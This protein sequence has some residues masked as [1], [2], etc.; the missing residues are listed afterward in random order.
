MS[1]LI[2]LE[3]LCKIIS[4]SRKKKAFLTFHSVGDRDGVASAVA[5]SSCFEKSKV[6]TPD[7]ITGN[8]RKMLLL[9]HYSKKIRNTLP[10]D[11]E[12]VIITDTNNLESLG[13]LGQKLLRFRGPIIFIDHH[14]LKQD[15][16]G[17]NAMLFN[18]EEYNSASSIVYEVLKENNE[19]I[20]KDTALMLLNGIISDSAGFQNSTSLTFAQ[21]GELLDIAQTS[22]SE[23]L[24]YFH[25]DVSSV[26]RY[27]IMK[28]LL[29]ATLEDIDGH[30]LMY[31]ATNSGASLA[32]E[33]AI[34]LGA[35]A[36]VFW[37]IRSKEASI[38]ARLRS[39]LDKKL[40]LN[41]GKLMQRPGELLGG[42]GGGHPC[43]AGAY[44]PR[45]ANAG[46]ASDY[47]IEELKR[48]FSQ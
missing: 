13:G 32:A 30:L 20:S 4:Q 31:G 25:S 28:D 38:S 36:S 18:S 48:K 37:S 11:A 24:D 10:D 34:N 9:S 8:A 35:D 21:V 43:A 45:K 29:S 5:L 12:L 7:F 16:L 3:E 15:R 39:P 44:G 1:S 33:I 14:V 40:G 23:I 27:V 19:E 42:S 26:E 41:L 22:Y 46:Q 47:I 17:E 2:D 6:A